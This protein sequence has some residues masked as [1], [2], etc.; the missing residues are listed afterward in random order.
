MS[1]RKLTNNEIE[2]ARK[3]FGASI[4]YDDVSIYNK[5]FAFFQPDNSGMTPNGSIYIDSK[6]IISDYGLSTIASF[7][8]AFFIHEMTHVWQKQ[9]KVLNPIASAIANSLRHAFFY[10]EAYKYTLEK[11][12]DLLDYRMEQQA[13]IIE[14]YARIQFLHTN[15]NPNF[16]SN[17]GT[18]EQIVGLFNS[19]LAKFLISPSYPGK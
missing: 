2:L 8:K 5:K 14:D 18:K 7:E 9:N 15:P 4:K 6:E 13:Q 3:I 1:G 17:R 11:N 19:V 10:S 16:I 12:K